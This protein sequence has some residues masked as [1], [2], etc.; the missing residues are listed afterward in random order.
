MWFFTKTP[1]GQIQVGIRDNANRV[2]YLGFR[3]PHT[4]AVVYIISAAFAGVAGSVYGMFQNLV[5]ADGHLGALVSFMPII[6]TMIG[7]VGSFFGPILGTAVFQVIEEIVVR[8]T[9]R[10][11]LVVGGLLMLIIMFIPGGIHGL[12]VRLKMKYAGA[13]RRKLEK[14]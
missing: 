12:T 2:D 3:V 6:N 14:V 1:F 11:E 8:F 9:D 7:G 5:S 10:V 4:K 13:A